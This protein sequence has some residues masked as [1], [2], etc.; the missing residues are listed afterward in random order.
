MPNV[1]AWQRQLFAC[2][3]KVD[4]ALCSNCMII[5]YGTSHYGKVDGQ[6]EEYA[7]TRF[8][9]IYY[10][11]LFPVSSWWMTG[12]E[13]GFATK[14]NWR[15]I[16]AAYARSWGLVL[17]T[18]ALYTAV[19]SGAAVIAVVSAAIGAALIAT[20][21]AAFRIKFR[22]STPSLLRGDFNYLAFGTHCDPHLFT[23][24]FKDVQ[25]RLLAER[26]AEFGMLRP[27]EDVARFGAANAME[28]ALAYGALALQPGANEQDIAQLLTNQPTLA[29][30]ADGGVYRLAADQMGAM[31]PAPPSEEARV[32]SAKRAA[33]VSLLANAVANA[34]TAMASQ[35]TP[36]QAQ[37]QPAS[38]AQ[39]Q[40]ASPTPP[41]AATN[42]PASPE[43]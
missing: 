20:S 16:G 25:R 36:S 4:A 21:V 22:R 19:A 8:A 31:V 17:G 10:M 1:A 23:R 5:V 26:T 28:A 34:Q 2:V 12:S 38:Q 15:S 40:P 9:H 13:R 7:M 29:V 33:E 14:F 32:D 6:G 43:K 18:L 27:P 3:P 24:E 30:K 11:P 39:S 37:G 42:T 41:D 35:G